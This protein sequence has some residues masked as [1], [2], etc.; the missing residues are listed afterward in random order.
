MTGHHLLVQITSSF[1]QLLMCWFLLSFSTHLLPNTIFNEA[2]HSLIDNF[3]ISFQLNNQHFKAFLWTWRGGYTQTFLHTLG[4]S[5]KTYFHCRRLSSL[6]VLWTT[7]PYVSSVK[8]I[9]FPT[10]DWI[11]V[12]FRLNLSTYLICTCCICNYDYILDSRSF[13]V[14]YH[15]LF[16]Y[17]LDSWKCLYM[18]HLWRFICFLLLI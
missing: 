12:Y 10:F 7:L 2:Q 18:A 4:E 8:L 13:G 6:L 1:N 15:T 16:N 3:S 9:V 14:Y 5:Y 17:A 11:I